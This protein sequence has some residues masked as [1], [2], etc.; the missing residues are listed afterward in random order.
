M[1]IHSTISVV[2]AVALCG[3]HSHSENHREDDSGHE[4]HHD[5]GEIVVSR[6]DASRFGIEVEAAKA[7][8]F[9][10]VVK[11][12]GEIMPIGADRAVVSALTSGIVTLSRGISEGQAVSAGQIIA[13]ISTSDVSG[14]DVNQAAKVALETANREVQRLKP[15]LDDGLITIKEYNEAVTAYEIA[16]AN[17]SPK[18][19]SKSATSPKSGV[20]TALHVAD[21]SYV[22]A[23]A[24]IAEVATTTQLTLRALLPASESN[25]LPK[26]IDAVLIPHDGTP[27]RL[28]HHNGHIISASTASGATAPGYI[29]VYFTFDAYSHGIVP[30][31]GVE[32]Y[33][34]SSP[35]DKVLSV[36][37]EALSE[38]LGQKF[39]YV[40]T[41]DH[42]YE[43]RPVT[44]GR[45]DG[46]RVAVTAGLEEGDSV[47][48]R[49]ATFV[50]LAE[51][52]T[53]VPEGHSHNH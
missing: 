46:E 5:D 10:E 20:L 7:A 23:G 26:I 42:A 8:P 28:S 53:I 21:G 34:C 22:E 1:K 9:A 29:P 31:S 49:G 43:K 11:V 17:F 36:P 3:C 45:T 19:A 2:V 33:L 41:E 51:Q 44:T 32:V 30:G 24:T 35:V 14:G 38:S 52:A 48:T 16:K 4:H 6:E 40:K 47:V 12:S 15:L 25:F 37:I 27:L 18:A 50:R 39:L 13:T